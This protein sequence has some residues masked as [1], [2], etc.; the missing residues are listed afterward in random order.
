MSDD[1]TIQKIEPLDVPASVQEHFGKKAGAELADFIPFDASNYRTTGAVAIKTRILVGRI[2][3][4]RMQGMTYNAIGKNMGIHPNA[5]RRMVDQHINQT[6]PEDD[7]ETLRTIMNAQYDKLMEAYYHEAVEMGNE[8]AAKI[9]AGAMAEKR[10]LNAVDKQVVKKTETRSTVQVDIVAQAAGILEK[11]GV[12]NV[13][14]AEIIEETSG[15]NGPAALSLEQAVELD[16]SDDLMALLAG[17][18]E[19]PIFIENSFDEEE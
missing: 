3:K 7:T 15:T 12:D 13:I 10:K 4:C 9:Y 1:K 16:I 2:I 5:A 17:E 19:E 8:S 11:I 14:D 18:D 6:F